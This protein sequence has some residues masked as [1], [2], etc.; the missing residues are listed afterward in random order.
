MHNGCD[1]A[2]NGNR[3]YHCSLAK[4]HINQRVALVFSQ[5]MAIILTALPI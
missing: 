4:S 2:G 5:I 3:F 1:D